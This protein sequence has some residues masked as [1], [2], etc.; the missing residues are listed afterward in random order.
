MDKATWEMVK[1]AA[2]IFAIPFL[3]GLA[4]RSATPVDDIVVRVMDL[5]VNDPTISELIVKE[6]Q[7][8]GLLE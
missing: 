5:A 8:R 1:G 6:L 3:T 4:K 7:A 2:N